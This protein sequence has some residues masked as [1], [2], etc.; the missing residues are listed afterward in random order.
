M[1]MVSPA[2]PRTRKARGQGH[3]RRGE[4][5]AAARGVFAAAGFSHATMRRIAAE[6]GVSP[7][8][9]YVYFPDKEAI[10][11][12]IA[13]EM[14][15]QLLSTL[16]RSQDKALSP[17]DRFRAGLLTYIRF[18]LSRPEEY[19]LTFVASLPPGLEFDPCGDADSGAADLSFDVL[20][21]GI[22]ELQE[23]GV[24]SAGDAKLRAEATWASLH[25]VT[26]LLLDRAGAIESPHD[27]LIGAVID[28]T[29]DAMRV[30]PL[31]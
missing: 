7:T 12:A 26:A 1:S 29:I 16:E 6:V 21:R 5:L 31:K 2:R 18:G 9:L 14:F 8:A 27:A 17:L 22:T 10:L 13:E 15:E 23:I 19:R 28:M 24:F 20:C 25:G 4:I 11:R 30:T 3:S